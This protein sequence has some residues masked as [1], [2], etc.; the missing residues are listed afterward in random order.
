MSG[1]DIYVLMMCLI[2]LVLLTAFFA[3]L[4]TMD[5]KSTLKMIAGGLMDEE[6]IETRKKQTAKRNKRV[7]SVITEIVLPVLFVIIVSVA[8]LF[9]LSTKI[10]E[11][12]RVNGLFAVKVVESG[13]MAVKYEKNEYLVKNN[14][15]DQIQRFD[16]IAVVS[17]PPESEIA[18]Y[19][20]I[21]YESDGYLIIHRVVGIEEPDEKHSERYFLMQGDAN[22]YP[23][24]FPV[25]YSQMKGL[26]R[27]TR[28]PY[29]GSFVSFMRSPAGYICF[30][31]VVF[32][33]AIYPFLVK[34]IEKVSEERLE[35]IGVGALL[36]TEKESEKE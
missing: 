6:L 10:N 29:V 1:F 18:L 4:I 7:L 11:K 35:T 24:R 16:L 5:Y 17:L 15:N 9:S 26:Y 28:I 13:S 25:R 19:D 27:G 20:I 30:A 22:R 3:L 2:V 31:L 36:P 21:M 32:A 23:D 33:C 12:G 14:L 34:K 8:F